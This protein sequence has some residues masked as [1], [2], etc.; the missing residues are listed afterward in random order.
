MRKVP[1]RR[2]DDTLKCNGKR[3]DLSKCHWMCSLFGG[4]E[5]IPEEPILT[6]DGDTIE[7]VVL[8]HFV[9]LCGKSE[10]TIEDKIRDVVK[11]QLQQRD[12]EPSTRAYSRPKDLVNNITESVMQ[13]LDDLF[14]KG[15]QDGNEIK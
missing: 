10:P 15:K 12:S 8:S 14:Y 5:Y 13:V 11:E 6:K 3:I 1:V 2:S 7:G 9:V 4:I